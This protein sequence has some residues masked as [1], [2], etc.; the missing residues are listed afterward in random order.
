MTAV[1]DSYWHCAD[2]SKVRSRGTRCWCQPGR[3]TA[4]RIPEG[5]KQMLDRSSP[6]GSGSASE[7]RSLCSCGALIQRAASPPG[8][9]AQR[10]MLEEKR[11]QC[12]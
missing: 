4:L 7:D 3:K 9:P 12:T 11:P 8:R 2:L 6:D 5:R 10:A 1:P